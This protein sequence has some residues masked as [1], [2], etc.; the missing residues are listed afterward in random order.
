MS[1]VPVRRMPQQP[2][3]QRRLDLILDTAAGLF[4]EIGYETATTN[5][6]AG[7]AGVSIGSLYRYFPDKDAILHALAARYLEPSRAFYDQI[8][9]GDLDGLPL[10]ALVDRLVDPF[11]DFCASQPAYRHILLGAEGSADIGA[12]AVALDQEFFDRIAN[13]FCRIAPGL[14]EQRG[15]LVATVCAA[16]VKALVSLVECPHCPE[17][18]DEVVAEV[19]RM[20]LAYLGPI[21]NEAPDGDHGHD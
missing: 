4:E 1:D 10:P 9:A 12:A 5:A 6:I 18:R 14:D 16:T 15:R 7:R 8:F 13:L 20:L 11:L 2:R 3:S 21:L 19:K 17:P